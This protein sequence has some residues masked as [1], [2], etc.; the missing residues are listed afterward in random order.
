MLS[1]NDFTMQYVFTLCTSIA[2]GIVAGASS[3]IKPQGEQNQSYQDLKSF[4]PRSDS[5]C[6]ALFEM[7]S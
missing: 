5:F 7:S 2:G 1:L 4:L 6:A 3:R